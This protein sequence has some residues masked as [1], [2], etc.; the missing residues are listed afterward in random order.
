MS[1]AIAPD[2]RIVLTG[3]ADSFDDLTLTTRNGDT[4][5]TFGTATLT[6]RDVA[7]GSIDAA[8]FIFA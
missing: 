2:A 5:V 4:F 7:I 8:D 1:E 3:A 6:L